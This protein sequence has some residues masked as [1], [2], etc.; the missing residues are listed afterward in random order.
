MDVQCLSYYL[1]GLVVLV[2]EQPASIVYIV[3]G[4]DVPVKGLGSV[5]PKFSQQQLVISTPGMGPKLLRCS[6][7]PRDVPGVLNLHTA[8]VM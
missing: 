4:S 5:P 8:F 1:E 3:C 7:A 2:A 6:V